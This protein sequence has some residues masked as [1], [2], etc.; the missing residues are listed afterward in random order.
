MSSQD[1]GIFRSDIRCAILNSLAGFA[2]RDPWREKSSA[3]TYLQLL[4]KD[5]HYSSGF[6]QTDSPGGT[7]KGETI[8][9]MPF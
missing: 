2:R 1:W 6:N 9:E 3:T 7:G 4:A 5:I 8:D